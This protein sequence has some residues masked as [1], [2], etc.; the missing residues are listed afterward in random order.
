MCVQGVSTPGGSAHGDLCPWGSDCSQCRCVITSEDEA[1][2]ADEQV[3]WPGSPAGSRWRR[4]SPERDSARVSMG[5]E[6]W[7]RLWDLETPA[8]L[9][10]PKELLAGEETSLKAPSQKSTKARSR[11]RRPGWCTASTKH[12]VA[13]A[14]H[15][16]AAALGLCQARVYEEGTRACHR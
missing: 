10:D 14:L 9:Q 2:P 4:A 11:R 3:T 16:L 5:R 7:G 6:H 13:L 1:G 15:K 8:Q 12:R